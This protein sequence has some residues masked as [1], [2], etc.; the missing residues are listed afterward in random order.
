VKEKH[1]LR[2]VPEEDAEQV[3]WMSTLITGEKTA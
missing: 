2:A 1:R 3:I